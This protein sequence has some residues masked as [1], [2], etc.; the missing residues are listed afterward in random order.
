MKILLIDDDAR[1]RRALARMLV[2]EGHMVIQASDGAEGMRIFHQGIPELAMV[3]II[4]PNREGIETIRELR[5]EAPKLCILAM[6]GSSIDY[7]K[8][9]R[10]LGADEI[11][12]KPFHL[13]ELQAVLS[14]LRKIVA[15]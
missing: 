4:M 5:R 3:D 8:M 12:S 10:S 6:S 15:P 1:F 7:L 9:A 2:S 11:I 14:R 13:A